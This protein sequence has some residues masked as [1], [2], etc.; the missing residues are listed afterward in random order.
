[1]QYHINAVILVLLLFSEKKEMGKLQDY[2]REYNAS[3]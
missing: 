3:R 1:L 2:H